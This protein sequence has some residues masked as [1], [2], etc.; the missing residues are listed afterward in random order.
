MEN[1]EFIDELLY[2]LE[3]RRHEPECNTSEEQLTQNFCR[4]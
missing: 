3:S 2:C 4:Y 1:E